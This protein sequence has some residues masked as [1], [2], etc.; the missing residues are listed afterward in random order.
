MKNILYLLIA[1]AT[2]GLNFF[3][4][5]V[6][7][8][9]S[10]AIVAGFWRYAIAVLI[11]GVLLWGKLPTWREI[12]QQSRALILVG[13]GGIFIFNYC[14]FVGLE[15]TSAVNAALIMSLN[16]ALTLILNRIFYKSR[17]SNWHTVGILIALFGV[18]L[19][20]TK[21]QVGNIG[22]FKMASG[23]I[24][25]WLANLAFAFYHL[26][27]K[28]Y[29]GRMQNLQFTFFITA[30]CCFCFLLIIQPFSWSTIWDYPAMFWYAALGMGGPGTALAYFSWNRGV[31]G[32][33]I[34]KAAIFMN[35]I[36]L[37]TSIFAVLFGRTLAYYHLWSGLL[38]LLGLIVIQ[39]QQLQYLPG[40]KHT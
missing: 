40:S 24:Y 26:G 5:K 32:M 15:H 27:V 13:V 33:G 20:T 4:A 29:G 34:G 10:S 37:F 1:T 16:P 7:M 23:D 12:R 11:L 22:A 8:E 14:F 35:T 9:S 21:G 39:L 31:A 38:I 25:L 19:L 6:M 36:P 18:I 30:V 17:I 3:L 28:K 2:W